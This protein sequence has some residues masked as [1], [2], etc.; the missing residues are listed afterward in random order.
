MSPGTVLK[1]YCE[2]LSQANLRVKTR[3]RI[4]ADTKKGKENLDSTDGIERVIKKRE[5]GT[6]PYF[7]PASIRSTLTLEIS[8]SLFATVSPPG[9][10]PTTMKSYV[11][12]ENVEGS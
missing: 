8:V 7:G 12:F 4:D 3:G 5:D 2:S 10:E 1:S 9:P 11:A 6:R